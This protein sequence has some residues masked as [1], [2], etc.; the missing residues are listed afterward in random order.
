M[1]AYTTLCEALS[2]AVFASSAAATWLPSCTFCTASPDAVKD[3]PPASHWFESYF[4]DLVRNA[5]P[6]L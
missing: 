4:L 5:S 1:S 6:P 3:A 2:S